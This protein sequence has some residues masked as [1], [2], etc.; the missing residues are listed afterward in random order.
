M[1][2]GPRA[3]EPGANGESAVQGEPD[4]G[5]NFVGAGVVPNSSQNLGVHC[6]VEVELL[7]EG[8]DGGGFGRSLR[9]PISLLGRVSKK[10]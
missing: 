6:I 2:G 10:G 3:L 7:D 8:A 1:W 4:E 5:A 9:V